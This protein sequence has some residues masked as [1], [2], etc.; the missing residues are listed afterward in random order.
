MTT[1]KPGLDFITDKAT[2]TTTTTKGYLKKHTFAF[3]H[4]YTC[5]NITAT[6]I[7]FVSV[8]PPVL[9]CGSDFL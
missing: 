9:T 7:I 2:T 3:K 4:T 1:F 5:S 6:V 8:K